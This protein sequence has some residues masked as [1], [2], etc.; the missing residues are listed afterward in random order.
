[1]ST[2][3]PPLEPWTKDVSA[4]LDAERSAPDPVPDVSARV[5]SAVASATAAGAAGASASSSPLP[6]RALGMKAGSL[7][8]AALLGGVVGAGLHAAWMAPRV[9]VVMVDRPVLV[10]VAAPVA[11]AASVAVAPVEA[12]PAAAE[13]RAITPGKKPATAAVAAV[14]VAAP[15]APSSLEEESALLDQA[16]QALARSN[17]KAA[18]DALLAHRARFAAGTF[19]EERDALEVRALLATGEPALAGAAAKAFLN[20]YPSSIHRAVMERAAQAN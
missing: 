6:A 1:M 12:P 10:T 15:V 3:Q 16:R 7:V 5:W 19:A 18:M 8:V 9:E 4:L 20:R 14:P 17:H 13:A 2:Q 11:P